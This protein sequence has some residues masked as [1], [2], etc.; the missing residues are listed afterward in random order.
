MDQWF[1]DSGAWKSLYGLKQPPRCWNKTL[2]ESLEGNGFI[3]VSA[4]PCVFVKKEDT[5]VII[6]VHVDDLSFVVKFISFALE[7]KG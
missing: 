5:L 3:Q 6:A 1:I 7:F 2:K 4:D